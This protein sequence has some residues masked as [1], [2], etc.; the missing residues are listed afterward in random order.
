MD[1]C[2]V[3]AFRR[4]RQ[5]GDITSFEFDSGRERF[6]DR[7]QSPGEPHVV[8][9]LQFSVGV[10]TRRPPDRRIGDAVPLEQPPDR[11]VVT[12]LAG[13]DVVEDR[14]TPRPVELPV[15]VARQPFLL[16]HQ[17]QIHPLFIGQRTTGRRSRAVVH[18]HPMTP[19][20]FGQVGSTTYL[21]NQCSSH[22]LTAGGGSTITPTSG[23]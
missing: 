5:V 3:T 4:R 7:G 19:L 1:G 11:V 18:I 8:G 23:Y 21:G 14:H 2:L 15:Q 13:G 22:Q 10:D 20:M 16:A 6:F 12:L 17:D 9:V